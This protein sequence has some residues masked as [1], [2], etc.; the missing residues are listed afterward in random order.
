LKDAITGHRESA[1]EIIDRM[2]QISLFVA[3]PAVHERQRLHM[4]TW[5]TPRFLRSYDETVDD[6]LV[7]RRGLTDTL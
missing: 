1:A 6:G 5:D 2:Q 3:E 7:L 4:S